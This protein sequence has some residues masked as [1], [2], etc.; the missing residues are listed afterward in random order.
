MPAKSPKDQGNYISEWFGHRVFPTVTPS[1]EALADQKA[2]RCP[3]LSVAKGS[4]ETCIK[5]DPSKGVCTVSSV[6]NAVRQDWLVCP[7][8]ALSP[9]LL[10]AAVHRLFVV[11]KGAAPL[12]VPAIRLADAAQREE[13]ELRLTKGERAMRGSW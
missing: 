4:A 10:R 12:I 8:R 1:V 3:F 11:K 6:S 9:E 5:R 13:I 7:W 2:K